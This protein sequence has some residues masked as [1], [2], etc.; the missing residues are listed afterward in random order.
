MPWLRQNALVHS[1]QDDDADRRV[2]PAGAEGLVS[3]ASRGPSKELRDIDRRREDGDEE[4]PLFGPK[5][6]MVLFLKQVHLQKVGAAVGGQQ[7]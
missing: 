2:L 1:E 7:S 3:T 6:M 5:G 4:S